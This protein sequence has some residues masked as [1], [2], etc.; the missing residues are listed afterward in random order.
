MLLDCI[1]YLFKLKVTQAEF[2]AKFFLIEDE[3]H[4]KRV[5]S[6]IGHL[7]Q[8]TYAQPSLLRRLH[9][10]ENEWEDGNRTGSDLDIARCPRGLKRHNS[11]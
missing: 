3:I 11:Q 9:C 2:T 8:Q 6:V 5:A 1:K 4:R 10:P 7:F